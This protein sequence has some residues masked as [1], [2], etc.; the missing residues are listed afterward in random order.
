MCGANMCFYISSPG[1]PLGDQTLVS[2]RA[3]FTEKTQE[4]RVRHATMYLTF[5]LYYGVEI[6][7]PS[8]TDAPHIK[9]VLYLRG[10]H[11]DF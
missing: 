2:Y 7:S 9:E 5:A 10:G 6:L 3:A 11:L 4:N 1:T 8:L